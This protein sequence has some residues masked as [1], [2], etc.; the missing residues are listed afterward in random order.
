M[1]RRTSAARSSQENTMRSGTIGIPEHGNTKM[2]AY[3][4]TG[5]LACEDT[6]ALFIAAEKTLKKE[7]EK[8]AGVLREPEQP[9]RDKEIK[10]IIH[11]EERGKIRDIQSGTFSVPF[12]PEKYGFFVEKNGKITDAELTEKDGELSEYAGAIFR[13]SMGQYL[14]IP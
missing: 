8:S 1:T 10:M 7:P 6:A 2:T 13:A 3:R 5:C 12:T 14:G 4:G 9:G 11:F